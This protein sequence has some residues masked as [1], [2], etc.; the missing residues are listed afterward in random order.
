MRKYCEDDVYSVARIPIDMEV[1]SVA[2]QENNHYSDENKMEALI[3]LAE[4]LGVSNNYV[5][6]SKKRSFKMV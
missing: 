1:E 6:Y 3:V 2:N 5:G 4:L